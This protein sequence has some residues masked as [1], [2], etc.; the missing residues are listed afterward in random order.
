MLPNEKKDSQE[1]IEKEFIRSSKN[2]INN[3]SNDTDIIVPFNVS[4]EEKE[5][6]QIEFNENFSKLES[7]DLSVID[8]SISKCLSLTEYNIKITS[9]NLEDILTLAFNLG[10]ENELYNKVLYFA[11]QI[12]IFYRLIAIEIIDSEIIS[13]YMQLLHCPMNK[14]ETDLFA[15]FFSTTF[16]V[17]KSANDM[18]HFIGEIGECLN[19]PSISADDFKN[20]ITIITAIIETYPEE[21]VGDISL[22]FLNKVVKKSI[23][24]DNNIIFGETCHLFMQMLLDTY[25]KEMFEFMI[26]TNEDLSDQPNLDDYL[27]QRILE[28]DKHIYREYILDIF[29]NF[30]CGPKEYTKIIYSRGILDKFME[31]LPQFTEESLNIRIV[32]I[33]QNFFDL[34]IEVVL[35]IASSGLTDVAMTILNDGKLSAKRDALN[36]ICALC[37]FSYEPNIQEFLIKNNLIKAIFEFTTIESPKIWNPVLYALHNIKNNAFAEGFNETNF[38][39]H[40]LFEEIDL[41]SFYQ[42]LNTIQNALNGYKKYKR[43]EY[44]YL[45]IITLDFLSIVEPIIVGENRNCET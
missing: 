22:Y 16:D 38:F 7:T 30:S 29:M 45:N 35:E 33:M 32:K 9:K 1:L 27:L 25:K 26:G 24:S 23:F 40:P 11:S 21:D 15:N 31:I 39:E 6:Y 17:V 36:Y 41:F 18:F 8:E 3:K 34:G 37:K 2:R 19:D 13:Q 10:R 4:D 42:T 14:A 43:D 44:E 5:K 12:L 28:V 20:L